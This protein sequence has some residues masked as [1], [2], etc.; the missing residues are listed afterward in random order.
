M[1]PVGGWPVFPVGGVDG[2]ACP[3]VAEPGGGAPPA[4]ACCATTQV[5]QNRITDNNVSFLADIIRPPA[6]N[7][8]VIPLPACGTRWFKEST[9]EF[10][11]RSEAA[12]IRRMP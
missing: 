6:L 3:G 9:T 12:H 1:L 2:D 7:F 5:A 8:L 4:G 11:R 10:A